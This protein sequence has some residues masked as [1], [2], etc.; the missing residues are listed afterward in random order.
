MILDS[1][2]FVIAGGVSYAGDLLLEPA[3][4]AYL[5]R[6]SGRGHRPTARLRMGMLGG[7]EAGI[8]GAADLA[9]HR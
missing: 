3:T 8:I 4:Q 9:R 2:T 5:S 6:L 1:G 7:D